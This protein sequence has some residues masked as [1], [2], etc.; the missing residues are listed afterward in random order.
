LALRQSR[1]RT[2]VGRRRLNRWARRRTPR[3]T[4]VLF[5]DHW[6]LNF[7][8]LPSYS[9]LE[10]ITIRPNNLM[11]VLDLFLA[12]LDPRDTTRRVPIPR[13]NLR[14]HLLFRL[15]HLHPR[16]FFF[17]THIPPH[18]PSNTRYI[19]VVV[20]YVRRHLL[21]PHKVA[22]E[23]NERVARSWDVPRR[24]LTRVR[25]LCGIWWMVGGFG[26]SVGVDTG[27]CGA[28]A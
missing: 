16:L 26:E 4:Y 24:L 1:K 3:K 13:M 15:C 7:F 9:C 12:R 6:R 22:P 8:H 17:V 2:S 27:A 19:P 14:M 25:F 5:L 11:S 21:L 23:E 20:R 18:T 28:G 10:P